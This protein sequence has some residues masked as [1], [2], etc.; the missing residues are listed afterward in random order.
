MTHPDPLT[1]AVQAA[2]DAAAETADAVAS[3]YDVMEPGRPDTYANMKTQK[4]AKGMVRL[5]RDAIRAIDPAEVL[6]KVG[7]GW[8]SDMDAAPR[9]G[10]PVLL[11]HKENHPNPNCGY[12][13]TLP[14]DADGNQIGNTLCLYH[15]HAEGL[16]SLGYDGPIVGVWGGSWEDSWEDGG[17][18]LPDWWFR[19]DD[20]LET[21]LN[22]T[23]WMPLSTPSQEA[24]NE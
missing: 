9:D 11:W 17:G 19:H 4:A 14:I 13:E 16:S 8:N 3:G 7:D 10:T 20:E 12:C 18:F 6:A 24:P 1:R 23:H 15:A 5:A 21:V 2:L 22:P